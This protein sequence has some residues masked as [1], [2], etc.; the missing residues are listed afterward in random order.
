MSQ[1]ELPDSAKF[2]SVGLLKSYELKV[3]KDEDG[4]Y[5]GESTVTIRPTGWSYTWPPAPMD[6]S[7]V[8]HLLEEYEVI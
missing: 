8:E 6:E 5:L 4:R 3:W 7:H 2:R 1:T